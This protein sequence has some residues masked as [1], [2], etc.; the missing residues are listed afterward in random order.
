MGRPLLWATGGCRST[1]ASD[2]LLEHHGLLC[3]NHPT[4][5]GDSDNLVWEA[6]RGTRRR[7]KKKKQ[8]EA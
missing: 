5:N 4:A 1:T 6:E 3:D 7:E 2:N 8:S